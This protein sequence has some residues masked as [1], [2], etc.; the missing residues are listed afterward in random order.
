[1]FAHIWLL[2]I[3]L[4]AAA[5]LLAFPIS[6]YQ[7]THNTA[8]HPTADNP[9][10]GGIWLATLRQDGFMTLEA[11][12]RGECWTQPATFEGGRRLVNSRNYS[13]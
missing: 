1:M 5:T 9:H 10:Q 4:L 13:Q 12:A 11:E 2:P 6:R 7:R 8:F 3:G